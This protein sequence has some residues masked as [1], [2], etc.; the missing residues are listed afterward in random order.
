MLIGISL[1]LLPLIFYSR[2]CLLRP[3]QTNQTRSLFQGITYQR[4]AR[5]TPRPVMIHIVT[6]DLSTPGVRSLVTPG[7]ATA[8]DTEVNARV[9]TDFVDEFKLQLAVNASFFYSFREKTPWDYYPHSGDR[10]NILGQIISNGQVYSPAISEWPVLCMLEN[11]RAAIAEAGTC[12]AKTVQA[13]AGKDL[14]VSQGKPVPLPPDAVND[15]PY[16]RTAVA[17]DRTGQ[18]LRFVVVDGKQ[19]FYSEGLTLVELQQLML[20]LGVEAALNLDG[21]GSTTLAIATP[22]GARLPN[23]PIHTKIPLRQRAIGSQLGFY[24]NRIP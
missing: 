8:D 5:L 7:A 24:A 23:A 2:L 4:I 14:L 11:Q 15:K 3:P 10:V 18:T 9:T 21:G 12:P 6:V 13:V 19:P 20:N 17:I 22:A 16:P 1:L